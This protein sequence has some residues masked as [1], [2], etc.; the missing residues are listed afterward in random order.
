MYR[1]TPHPAANDCNPAKVIM[2]RKTRTIHNA[3]LPK[4]STSPNSSSCAKNTLVTAIAI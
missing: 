3:L 2:G 4:D 1:M